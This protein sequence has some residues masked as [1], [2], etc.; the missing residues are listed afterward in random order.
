M[1]DL[2]RATVHLRIRIPE[3][4]WSLSAEVMILAGFKGLLLSLM[5]RIAYTS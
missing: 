2:I 1:D 5:L 4:T 3:F